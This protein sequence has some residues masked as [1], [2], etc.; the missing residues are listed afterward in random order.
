MSKLVFSWDDDKAK[1]NR[2]KHKVSFEEA[3]TVFFDENAVEYFDPDHSEDEDRFLMLGIS[4]RLRVLV[5]CDCLRKD[6]SEIR[7]ISART[8]TKKEQRVY[9][10]EIK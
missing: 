10:G 9:I 2:K 5:V 8:T 7:I 1:Q 3:S 6:G 4:C